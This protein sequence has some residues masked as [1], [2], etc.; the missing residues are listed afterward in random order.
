MTIL[1][2]TGAGCFLALAL[3]V[4][5]ALRASAVGEVAAFLAGGLLI[6]AAA[7]VVLLGELVVIKRTDP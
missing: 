4:I 3:V 5:P 2:S 6:V 7:L 1:G